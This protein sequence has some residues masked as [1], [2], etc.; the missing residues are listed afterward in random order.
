MPNTFHRLV[1]AFGLAT[2][3][4]LHGA[5]V[6][7]A[8]GPTPAPYRV[9]LTQPAATHFAV[10]G[11]F[12]KAGVGEGQVATLVQSWKPDFIITTGD[13]NYPA[14]AAETL[15]DNVGQYYHDYIEFDAT[16]RGRYKDQGS[17]TNRFFPALGNHDWHNVVGV[18]PYLDYF[19]LPGNERYYQFSAG[20]VDFFALDSDEHEPDGNTANSVQAT[21]L[22]AALK[23]STA[24][25]KIVYMHHPPYSSGQHGSNAWMHWPFATW[26]ASLVLSGHDHDYEHIAIDHMTYLVCGLGGAEIDTFAAPPHVPQSN[27]D[28]GYDKQLGAMDVR[29]TADEMHLRFV[30]IDG[31]EI[32]SFRL[33]ANAATAP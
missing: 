9:S 5:C 20:P 18:R 11:D 33:R 19:K 26:G 8:P 1:S 23:A 24:A 25:W 27:M 16:Y 22:R 13:N 2:V 29:A 4:V 6:T 17:L 30:T 21:W 15:D 7:T 32:D 10:I 28:V 31:E 14:G 12:G 3:V